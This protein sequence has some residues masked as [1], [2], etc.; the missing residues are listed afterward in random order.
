MTKNKE[1]T[2][3]QTIEKYLETQCTTRGWLCPKSASPGKNGFPDRI[4][5]TNEGKV[6]FVEVKRPKEVPR[7]LQ[8]K[9]FLIPL[10]EHNTNVVVVSTHEQVDELI[11]QIE[12]NI[13]IEPEN[14]NTFYIKTKTTR[15]E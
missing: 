8:L 6:I 2:L 1:R 3:E 7:K 5:I 13:K 14:K 11:Q 4:V 12:R 10:L 15:E 9:Q